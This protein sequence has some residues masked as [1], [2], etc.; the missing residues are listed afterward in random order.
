M[1]LNAFVVLIALAA[2]TVLGGILGAI[3]AVPLTAAAW[4]IVQVWDGPDT[5]A[6]WARRKRPEGDTRET[7]PDRVAQRSLDRP[8]AERAARPKDA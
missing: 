4:G 7:L 2:G 1:R 8:R 5:P 6:R 3:L